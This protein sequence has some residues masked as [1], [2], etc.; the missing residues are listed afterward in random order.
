MSQFVSSLYLYALS[1]WFCGIMV[2]DFVFM[3]G[4][5]PLTMERQRPFLF[6]FVLTVFSTVPGTWSIHRECLEKN[7]SSH[8]N[9]LTPEFL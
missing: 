3:C 4:V 9:R 7:Y 6:V 2:C 5:F 1:L 8:Y